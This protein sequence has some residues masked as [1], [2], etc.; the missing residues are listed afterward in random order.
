MPSGLPLT[1][2]QEWLWH[3]I[4]ENES[5]QCAAATAFRL[6][7]VLNV[8]L[9]EKCLQDVIHR[10]CALR[11]HIAVFDGI[12][13]QEIR[14]PQECFLESVAVAGTS[15][16]QVA[17]NARGC[18]EDLCDRKM[19]VRIEP[20]WSARLLRLSE[21][22]HW[23][24]L[25]MHRLIG[26]CA[27]IDQTYHET[28]SLYDERQ[29]GRP[30]SLK[31]PAQY[32]DYTGWQQQTSGEWLKRHEPYWTRRL[33]EATPLQ[34]RTD[35]ELTPNTPG[36]L[37]KV[38]CSFGKIL[39]AGMR[40]LARAIRT[41]PAMP[42]LAIYAAVL[43]R[44][45]GKKDF[46]LPF[47]TAGRPTEY[48]SAIGYFSYALCLRIQITGDETFTDLVSRV[49]S[50]FFNALSHQDFGR[51]A[52]QRP[53]L[54][55]GTLFQWLTWHPDDVPDE[56]VCIRDFGEGLT[57]VPPGMTDIEVTVFDTP[58]EFHAFGSYRADRFAPN[59]MERFMANLPRAAQL[60]VH[61]PDARIAA[62][63]ETGGNDNGAAE[64]A[65][66]DARGAAWADRGKPISGVL[67]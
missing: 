7:G 54:I 40:D 41:L 36:R 50:E 15:S 28:K 23:L 57:V 5:W 58:T 39:S 14:D 25:T 17:L 44:W 30:S 35:A 61:N 31:R 1:F 22:E 65:S 47:N 48:K 32:S 18:V 9:L 33:S 10:H 21:H 2:Q 24:V 60:F 67:S 66:S 49:A 11:T 56:R 20:L 55:S 3:I 27:S 13:R 64:P 19:N 62:V 45:C 43:W 34:W 51:I 29:Q 63:A 42:M 38:R 53:E 16:E 52:R 8:S 26:D 59:T 12:I 46:V 4:R 6:S 37:G